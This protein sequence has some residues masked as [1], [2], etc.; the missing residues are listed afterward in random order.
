MNENRLRLLNLLLLAALW[1]AS[2]VAWPRVPD[3]IPIHFDFAGNPDA[4]AP[5]T[6]LSWFMLP[7]IT[8]GL[9]LGLQALA[10]AGDQNPWLWNIPEKPRFV[11]LPPDARAPIT[12]RLRGLVALMSVL[13]TVLLALVQAE[14]YAAATSKGT[15]PWLIP[16]AL[17]VMLVLIVAASVV[18]MRKVAADV[19]AAHRHAAG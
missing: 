2:I 17:G 7:L 1:A 10:R 11:A 16:G 5:R 8:T 6:L 13:A 15:M 14:V 18:T 19:R 9:S 3:R 4:W 12:A